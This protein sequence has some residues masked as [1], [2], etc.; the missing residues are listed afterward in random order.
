MAKTVNSLEDLGKAF[1]IKP[2]QHKEK[3]YR[4]KVC[5]GK[6]MH[7]NNVLICENPHTRV[8]KD[9]QDEEFEYFVLQRV[10]R[11]ETRLLAPG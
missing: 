5:G 8:G 9:G 2:K 6:M 11:E 3:E 10:K 7:I 1:G 4:C